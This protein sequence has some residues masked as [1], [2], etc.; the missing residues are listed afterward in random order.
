MAFTNKDV[1]TNEEI[2][3][4]LQE[5]FD[6]LEDLNSTISHE[7]LEDLESNINDLICEHEDYQEMDSVEIDFKAMFLECENP[8]DSDDEIAINEAFNN[9]TDSLCK[10]S[11]ISDYHYNNWCNTITP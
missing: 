11:E 7:D 4:R 3:E 8:I 9:Y 5:A 1:L 6:I 2:I 10:D